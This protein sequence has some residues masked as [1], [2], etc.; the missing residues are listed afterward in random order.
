MNINFDFG[1]FDKQEA[2]FNAPQRYAIS[3]SATKSGK[4]T[5]CSRW[6]LNEALTNGKAMYHYWW[7]APVYKQASIGFEEM[8]KLLKQMNDLSKQQLLNNGYSTNF[9][10]SFSLYEAIHRSSSNLAITLYNGAI[11]DFKSADNPN[12]LYGNGVYAVVFDEASRADYSAFEALES[13]TDA[14]KGKKRIIANV[15]DEGNWTLELIRKFKDDPDWFITYMDADDRIR[16]GLTTR[17]EVEAKRKTMTEPMF[18]SLYYNI[19]IKENSEMWFYEFKKDKHIKDV[20]YNLDY[21]VYVCVDFNVNPLCAIVVQKGNSNNSFFHVIKEYRITNATLDDLAYLINRDFKR[22]SNMFL[23]AD[24]TG[25]NRDVGYTRGETN[26]IEK[27]K[28]LLGLTD[29][30]LKY[31]PKVN[32][33]YANSREL[34]NTILLHH[35][36]VFIDTNCHYLIKDLTIAKPEKEDKLF[37][38]NDTYNMNLADCFRYGVNSLL[39]YF[40]ET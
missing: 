2:F 19:P 37:K 15:L 36:N 24:A 11:I 25:R 29:Y 17:E 12:N 3:V 6:L 32:P 5:M 10:N 14:T 1:L 23:I 4:T 18:L 20:K 40:I 34:C 35:N 31:I 33:S 38:D 28:R 16:W 39:E 7:L 26:K 9:V 27:L 21:P 22:K 8:V 30:H 13:V